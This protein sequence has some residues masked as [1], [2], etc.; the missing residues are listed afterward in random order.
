MSVRSGVGLACKLVVASTG[1]MKTLFDLHKVV[2]VVAGRCM[3]KD[4]VDRCSS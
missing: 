3:M 2:D 1:R 4:R